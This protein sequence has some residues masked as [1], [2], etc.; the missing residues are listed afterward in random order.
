MAQYGR[1]DLKHLVNTVRDLS[2]HGIGLRVLA[3]QGAQIDTTTPTG[4]PD[5]EPFRF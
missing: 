1:R 4:K 3:G 5:R 2:D